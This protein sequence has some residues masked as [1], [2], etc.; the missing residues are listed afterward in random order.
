MLICHVNVSYKIRYI[1][2]G[3]IKKR[4]CG[5]LPTEAAIAQSVVASISKQ[6][7]T[8]QKTKHQIL[9][10]RLKSD[11]TLRIKEAGMSYFI[12]MYT[13]IQIYVSLSDTQ[14]FRIEGMQM[15]FCIAD[16]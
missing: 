8:K 5:T 15:A 14:Q 13:S 11:L 9:S 3:Y 7:R 2:G 12:S 10:E 1:L 4:Y 16:T 6:L